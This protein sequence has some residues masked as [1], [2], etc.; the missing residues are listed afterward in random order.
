MNEFELIFAIF[1]KPTDSAHF[2]NQ[3][4]HSNLIFHKWIPNGEIEM[5]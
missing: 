5:P 4:E 3:D 1:F 2:F